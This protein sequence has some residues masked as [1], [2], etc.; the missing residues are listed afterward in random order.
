MSKLNPFVPLGGRAQSVLGSVT[1]KLIE[2][3]ID[4]SFTVAVSVYYYPA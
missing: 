4:S 3:E 2:L 1:E